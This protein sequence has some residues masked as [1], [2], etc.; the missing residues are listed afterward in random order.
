MTKN[1]HVIAA[2]MLA[3]LGTTLVTGCAEKADSK[4]G[5]PVHKGDDKAHPRQQ[6]PPSA[7]NTTPKAAP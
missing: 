7:A 5:A 3:L 4:A 1:A 2:S 6:R